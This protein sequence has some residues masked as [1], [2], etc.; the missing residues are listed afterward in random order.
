MELR[1]KS[2]R[3]ATGLDEKSLDAMGRLFTKRTTPYSKFNYYSL[4]YGKQCQT[5]G[6]RANYD[7]AS[8]LHWWHTG[9][10]LAR[11]AGGMGLI[12]VV[13]YFITFFF[14]FFRQHTPLIQ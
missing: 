13:D 3:E 12:P 7:P 5:Q 9:K 4:T 8:E 14:D 11:H 6:K 10:T 1:S 2:Q